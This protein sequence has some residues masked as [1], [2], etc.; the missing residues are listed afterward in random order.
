MVFTETEMAL[1]DRIVSCKDKFRKK[2][3]GKYLIQLAM[4]GG[5]LN[6]KHDAPPGNMVLWRGFSRLIDINIG[7]SLAKDVG[8]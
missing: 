5:Y 2:T 8:N 7:F 4:L 6:R 1:L 3:V